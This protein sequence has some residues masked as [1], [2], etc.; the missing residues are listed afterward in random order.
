MTTHRPPDPRHHGPVRDARAPAPAGGRPGVATALRDDPGARAPGATRRGADPERREANHVLGLAGSEA[1]WS[2]HVWTGVALGESVGVMLL[3]YFHATS[4]GAQEVLL[5]SVAAALLVLTPC[6][7][8]L[9][10][11][12]RNPAHRLLAMRWWL[13]V[14]TFLLAVLANAGGSEATA[15]HLILVG[16]VLFAAQVFQVRTVTGLAALALGGDLAFLLH[17]VHSEPPAEWMLLGS[18][19]LFCVLA[20]TGA[21]NRTRN[22]RVVADLAARLADAAALDPLTG[23]ANRRAFDEALDVEVLRLRRGGAPFLLATFDLDRFKQVNDTHGHAAGDDLLRHVAA[24]V[25]GAL[26][27]SD[28]VAR[29]G[30][31][32]FSVLCPG[33]TGAQADLIAALIRTAVAGAHPVHRVT[34]SVGTAAG[35]D[36]TETPDGIAARA[37]EAMYADKQR[38][39]AALSPVPRGTP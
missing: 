39:G 34:A 20:V 10:G 27:A 12:L 11:R 32:E 28:L 35:A 15:L 19:S 7:G 16:P 24:A 31:D 1:F 26:R 2:S 18:M 8:A 3:A 9:A 36:P 25:R 30:G 23:L 5:D 6:F 38:T 4:Q 14:G 37:D 21:H 13:Y 33:T 17:S 29:T 22:E